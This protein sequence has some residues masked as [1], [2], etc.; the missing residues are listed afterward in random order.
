MNRILSLQFGNCYQRRAAGYELAFEQ[1]SRVKHYHP[2]SWRSYLGTQR[3]QGY[4]RV[5]LHL[6]QRGHAAGDSYSS[7]VDHVQPPLAMLTL[8]SLVLLLAVPLRW[9]PIVPLALLGMAQIPMTCR[10]LR[11]LRQ[12]RYL[13][14]GAM[15]FLRAFWRGVGMIQGLVGCLVFRA[16]RV[17]PAQP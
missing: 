5:Y 9:I 2:T 17:S 3:Q 7:F 1:A 8:A 14:F 15:S 13:L 4:W 16:R 6:S 11:R 10:L 12:W